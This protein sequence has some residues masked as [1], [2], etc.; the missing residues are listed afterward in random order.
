MMYVSTKYRQRVCELVQ[1]SEHFADVTSVS[2]VTTFTH[3][4][5]DSQGYKCYDNE[6]EKI[7]IVVRSSRMNRLRFVVAAA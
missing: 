4:R 6:E 1:K 7:D 5:R 3:P 2:S